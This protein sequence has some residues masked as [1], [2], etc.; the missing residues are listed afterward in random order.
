MF[1][2]N[3][4]PAVPGKLCQPRAIFSFSLKTALVEVVGQGPGLQSLRHEGPRLHRSKPTGRLRCWYPSL[5]VTLPYRCRGPIG[6]E[7]GRCAGCWRDGTPSKDPE[8]VPRHR[9]AL[10]LI[11][12]QCGSNGEEGE[13]GGCRH[14]KL[15]QLRASPK[16]KRTC[17]F[18]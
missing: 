8:A 10:C 14:L 13:C 6:A 18:S 2:G 12:S 4:R 9:G 5:G 15:R 11:L 17:L 16:L 7:R 3:V 1:G